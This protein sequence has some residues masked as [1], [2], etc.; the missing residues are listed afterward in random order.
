MVG[1]IVRVGASAEGVAKLQSIL[2]GTRV[3]IDGL[4][5]RL[6]R[7]VDGILTVASNATP[8]MRELATAFGEVFGKLGDVFKNLPFATVNAGVRG[9]QRRSPGSAA[10]SH[11]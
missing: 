7:L 11:R 2:A 5:P 3:F 1:Q 10:S 6:A 8:A 4:G 9:L